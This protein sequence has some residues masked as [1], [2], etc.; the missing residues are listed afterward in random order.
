MEEKECPDCGGSG[1]K[2]YAMRGTD[3]CE[4]CEGK[5]VIYE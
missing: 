1:E 5:G 4:T 3:E 2:W